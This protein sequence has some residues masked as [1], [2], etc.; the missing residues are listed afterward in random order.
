MDNE[1]TL[2]TTQ[3]TSVESEATTVKDATPFKVFTSEEDYKKEIQSISSK[4]KNDLLQK[5]E[6]SSVDDYKSFKERYTELENINKKLENEKLDLANQINTKNTEILYAKLGINDENKNDFEALLKA[7]LSNNSDEDP[8]E[9]GKKIV[10][11]YFNKTNKEVKF[12][13]EKHQNAP[14]EMDNVTREFLK[15]NPGMKL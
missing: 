2:V 14:Q 5:L 6:I 8:Y 1:Q 11:T 12:G 15:R 13:N 3:E 4:A 10:D 9:I 7:R